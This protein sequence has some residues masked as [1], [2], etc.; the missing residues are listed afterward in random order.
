MG[1]VRPEFGAGVRSFTV[2]T[3]VI[4]F[5]HEGDVLIA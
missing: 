5:R 3:Y 2:K 1:R 4:Y